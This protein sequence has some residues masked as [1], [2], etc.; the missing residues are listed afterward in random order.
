MK[1]DSGT[2]SSTGQISSTSKR[3][4]SLEYHA[5]S[6]NKSSCIVGRSNVSRTN[7]REIPPGETHGPNFDK[8]SEPFSIFYAVIIEAGDLLDWTVIIDD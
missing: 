6:D 7:G 2:I 5:R 8:G 1:Y 4:K 3:I